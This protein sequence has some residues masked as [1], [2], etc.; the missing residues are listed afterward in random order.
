MTLGAGSSANVLSGKGFIGA[1]L[2][3]IVA[4]NVSTINADGANCSNAGSH[5]IAAEEG[6]TINAVLAIIQ[7]QTTG[8]TRIRVAAGS[9]INAY[10][11]N[12]TGGTVPVFSQAVNTLTGAGII[13]Q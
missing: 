9:T 8:T 11:I 10:G 5:G 2:Y 7:N 13:Y 4:Q 6:S 12:T 3:G 1:G